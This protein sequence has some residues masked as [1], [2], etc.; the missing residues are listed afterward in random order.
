MQTVEL[1][2]GEPDRAP[3]DGGD[4]GTGA[5]LTGKPRWWLAGIAVLLVV[6]LGA[7]QWVIRSREDAAA[8]RLAAVDGVVAEVDGPLDIARSYSAMDAYALFGS[9]GAQLVR[10]DDGSLTYR[11]AAGTADDPGWST[12]VLGPVPALAD[13]LW[14]SS[15]SSCMPDV[16]PG[17]DV[18]TATRV[19]CLI[20]DGGTKILADDGTSVEVRAT[21]TFVEV[22][23][24]ADGMPLAQW[25]A[26]RAQTYA[27]NGEQIVLGV[28]ED[29]ADVFTGRDLLAGDV[30]WTHEV[31]VTEPLL[32]EN[33]MM[34]NV[35]A[36]RAGDLVALR[37]SSGE[38]QLLSGDGRVVRDGIGGDGSSS[39]GWSVDPAGRLLA[40]F[41]GDDAASA[42]VTVVAP[43]GDPS[44]DRILTG[45]LVQAEVDDGSV[46]DLVLTADSVL[47]AWDAKSGSELWASTEA[48]DLPLGTAPLSVLVV[49]GRLYV[50][51][52][53]G[54]A[55]LDGRTGE[56]L[57]RVD[58]GEGEV[59]TALL[60]DAHHLL[61]AYERS[62][63]DGGSL[64]VAYDFAEGAEVSHIPYPTGIDHLAVWDG[65][66][67]G[68]D[69]EGTTFALLR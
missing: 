1:L 2:D 43:D 64:L 29:A 28:I 60:T 19:V 56:T 23:D 3:D 16:E 34:R 58:P 31:P 62:A 6:V 59:P 45:S 54:V 47:H 33:P 18:S 9:E 55:A 35:S 49:R 53:K 14:V 30:R 39:W 46:P 69:Q 7:A 37:V 42:S 66:L 17:E 61:I 21:T 32:L 57:W 12:P 25:P 38:L 51:S 20:T 26:P 5:W 36:S 11:W 48:S 4:A 27:L 44:A 24:T 8:A 68:Y 65:Q 67:I 50:L 63:R 40:V 15:T 22:L 52:E 41:W 10:G 13:A